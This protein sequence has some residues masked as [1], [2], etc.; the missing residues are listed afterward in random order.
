MS[1]Y[2]AVGAGPVGRETARILAEEGHSVV[3]TS[4]NPGL[5]EARAVRT[6]SADATNAVQLAEISKG[7]EAIFM[8]AMAAYDRWP[9]D[10]FPIVDGTVKAAEETGA[11]I[12]VLGNL[13]GYGESA[14]SPLSPL[15]PLNPTSRKGTVR[16]IMWERAARSNVPAIEVRAS[17]Y[18]GDGAITY[19]SLLALPSLLKKETVSFPGNLDAIHAWSFTKDTAKTLVSAAHSTGE[20]NRAFHVPNQHAS[21][22]EL[23]EKFAAALEFETPK[24]RELTAEELEAIGFH[25]GV[26]MRYL[27]DN[28]LVVDASDTEQLLGV[29]ASSLEIMIQETLLDHK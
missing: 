22:R 3:L 15:A 12:V 21:I 25:E 11:K 8:C 27:F 14:T 7:A 16:G 24:L 29:T 17:D 9:T 10:F 13:Y 2:V 20:W 4:R 6:I 28:P 1:Y 26:E 23:T 18:L 19:F 5:I